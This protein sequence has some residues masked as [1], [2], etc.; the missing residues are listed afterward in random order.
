MI[1]LPHSNNFNFSQEIIQDPLFPKWR[2]V[3]AA[4]KQKEG[5]GVEIDSL[6][7]Q[8]SVENW[9]DYLYFPRPEMGPIEK[10][11]SQ[12]ERM[13]R[14]V[15]E[16]RDSKGEDLISRI[17][18]KV[19]SSF[20]SLSCLCTGSSKPVCSTGNASSGVLS[21]VAGAFLALSGLGVLADAVKQIEEAWKHKNKEKGMLALSQL[22]SGISAAGTGVLVLMEW[23]ARFMKHTGMA[24]WAGATFP[25]TAI[26]LYAA[27]FL[28]SAYKVY[29]L[30]K[31][32]IELNAR[33]GNLVGSLE[34][35]KAQTQLIGS[36][37]LEG[38]PSM[39][40]TLHRKWEQFTLRAGTEAL[41]ELGSLT[42]IDQLISD[43]KNGDIKG[44]EE[45]LNFIQKVKEKNSEEMKWQI[46][47]ALG[48]LAGVGISITYIVLSGGTGS[49]LSSVLFGLA[50][51][52]SLIAESPKARSAVKGIFSTLKELPA[53]IKS[54]YASPRR[55]LDFPKG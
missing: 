41:D 46:F 2:G 37:T 47:S 45:A 18:K 23:T 24:L 43:V 19:S 20:A 49:A 32:Q 27:N 36:E 15:M 38:E 44:T 4:E 51:G 34:W 50:S 1:K 40:N 14:V 16:Q 22:V 52:A 7:N 42:Q 55:L 25:I 3:A 31:F 5:R 53:L 35:I 11:P 30:W 39:L 28:C 13:F 6:L 12:T 33:N 26:G 10:I 17:S 48:N 8:T 29:I 21:V 9:D 54:E